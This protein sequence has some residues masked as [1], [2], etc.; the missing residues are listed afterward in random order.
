VLGPI[1]AQDLIDGTFVL[2]YISRGVFCD[3][4][5]KFHLRH[6]IGRDLSNG[7]RSEFLAAACDGQNILIRSGIIVDFLPACRKSLPEDRP[8]E[9]VA[10]SQIANSEVTDDMP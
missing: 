4:G 6:V 1:F 8:I 10:L 2:S 5:S 7:Q 9:D 3:C